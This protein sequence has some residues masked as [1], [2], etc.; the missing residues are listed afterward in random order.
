[1]TPETVL[2]R[3]PQ[4]VV[5]RMLIFVLSLKAQAQLGLE[6]WFGLARLQATQTHLSTGTLRLSMMPETREN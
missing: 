6:Q 4:K 1:L 3:L 5:R 2:F